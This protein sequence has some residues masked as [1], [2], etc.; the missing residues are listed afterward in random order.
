MKF[1]TTWQC[2]Q[3]GSFNNP[4]TAIFCDALSALMRSLQLSAGGLK[5]SCANVKVA[6]CRQK[7]SNI[8]GFI[9]SELREL[10]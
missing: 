3:S 7:V 2:C 1:E 6:K 5:I 8:R 4:S 10:K 9:M